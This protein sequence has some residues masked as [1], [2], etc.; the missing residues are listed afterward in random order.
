MTDK[1][2]KMSYTIEALP[3]PVYRVKYRVYDKAHHRYFLS[4]YRAA[5]FVAWRMIADR[6]PEFGMVSDE[7]LHG[8]ICECSQPWDGPITDSRG[9]PLHD[10]KDGYYRRLHNRLARLILG[11][12]EA[13]LVEATAR[14]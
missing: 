6:Y 3:R 4:A 5:S 8:K 2:A 14:K 12:S 7:P 13:A 1:E 11:N 9:C 10:T